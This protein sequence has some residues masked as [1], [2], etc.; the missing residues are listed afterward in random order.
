MFI[1]RLAAKRKPSKFELDNPIYICNVIDPENKFKKYSIN[2]IIKHI[3][4]ETNGKINFSPTKFFQRIT[5]DD[6]SQLASDYIYLDKHIDNVEIYSPWKKSNES[7][8]ALNRRCNISVNALWGVYSSSKQDFISFINKAKNFIDKY[9]PLENNIT[10]SILE[11]S[12]SFNLSTLLSKLHNSPG[13]YYKKFINTAIE[14]EL[15]EEDTIKYLFL[16]K[17]KTTLANI[18]KK[19][20]INEQ[21]YT[22]DQLTGILDATS[23][24]IKLFII[25][26]NINNEKIQIK[27]FI[28]KIT[29]LLDDDR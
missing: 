14:Q 11:K 25:F 9:G 20:K 17:Y 3:I 1:S 24:E 27:P 18:E 28:K 23:D 8:K 22:F 2:D 7:I 15:N 29:R 12:F 26:D 10:F 19:L 6:V 16:D 21:S 5:D 4:I 13:K